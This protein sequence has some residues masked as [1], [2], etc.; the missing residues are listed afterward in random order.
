MLW[1]GI[2]IGLDGIG[3]LGTVEAEDEVDAKIA[4]EDSA[5]G[6]V[7]VIPMNEV[8]KSGWKYLPSAPVRRRQK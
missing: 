7:I 3:L 2:C 4:M 8:M 5:W 1:L 6:E